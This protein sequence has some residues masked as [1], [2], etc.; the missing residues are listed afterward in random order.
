MRDG[1][2]AGIAVAVGTVGAPDLI[3]CWAQIAGRGLL[4]DPL[5]AAGLRGTVRSI[6]RIHINYA[7][8]PPSAETDAPDAITRG[9]HEVRTFRTSVQAAGT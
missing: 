4:F 2:K 1:T 8:D 6:C 5:Y 9:I 3:W 7:E